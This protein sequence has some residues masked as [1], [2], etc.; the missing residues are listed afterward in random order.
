LRDSLLSRLAA[1]FC[2]CAWLGLG[3]LPAGADI[4]RV[5][6]V[7][8]QYALTSAND[9]P[10]R[11]PQ[12]W[13][14]LASND[15]G[16]TWTTL[17]VR[18]NEVFQARQQR[19]L[20]PL[21]QHA[22]YETY[23]LQIDRVRDPAAGSVQLAELELMGSTEDDLGP[24]P[25]FLDAISAQGDNPPAETVANLFDGRVETKWLDWSPH[26]PG[27]ISWVQWQY[28]AADGATVTN[29]SQLLA[30]R[31]RAG[32]GIRVRI[33]AVMA[34]RSSQEN[35]IYLVD[36]TGCI[37]LAGIEGAEDCG[38]GQKIMISGVSEWDGKRAGIGQG[39]A[40]IVG[41]LADANP[42]HLLLDHPLPEGEDLKWVEVEGEI[43]YRHSTGDETAF[44]VQ[45]ELSSIR[46]HLVGRK[47][48]PP[49]PRPGSRVLVRG[50]CLGAFNERGQWV[51]A[52]LWA[53][54]GES[55]II[56]DSHLKN[57]ALATLPAQ[58]P[59]APAVPATLTT[60]E[61]IR[62]LTREQLK[63]HPQ[64][65]IHAVV[66]DQL[67]GFV[68]D[69]T[70]GIEVWFPT[71]E[72]RK[73][74][75]LGDYIDINGWAG[76][77]DGGSPEIYA[78]H[79]TDAGRGKL[80]RPQKLSASQLM[81]GRIDGQ[82][83]EV[84]GVVHSTDGS[85]VLIISYGQELMATLTVAPASLVNRLVDADVRVRGVGVTATDDQGRVQ[86]THLLIPSLDY[87]DVVT[88]PIEPAKLPIRKIGS[89]LG[90]SGPL[91]S[92]HRVR[93]EGV[94]TLHEG[95]TVF[96]QDDTGSA[97]AILKENVVLGARFGHSRW[98]Y[99]QTPQSEAPTKPGE[100]YLP[101]D[102][103]MAV[104]FAETHRYSPVLTEATLTKLGVRQT[105]KP[106]A[107]T[108]G[109]I[110]EGGLDSS[111]VKLEG[112]LRNRNS[113]GL[114]TALTLEWQD[115]TLQVLVPGK[116]SDSLKLALGSRLQ[117]TGVCQVDPVPYA[118]LGLGIGAVRILTRSPEDVLVLARPP[119]WTARRALMLTGGMAL[120]I[121]AAL[122]WIKALRRQ[123]GER[124]RQ[125]TAEIQRREQTERHRALEQER[126]RIAK[127]LHDDL[128]ANLTQIVFLSDRVAVARHEGQEVTHWFDLIPATARRTIQSLDE[129]VWAINPRH[130]SL[131]SLANYL[132]QFAQQH[133]ALAGVRCLLDVPTV[134][135]SVPLTAEVRHNLL[136]TVREALQN[137]VT[138][139]AATEVQLALKLNE[140]G[141]S[142]T[143]ADNGRGFEPQAVPAAGDGLQ[144][145]RRRLQTIGGRLEIDSQPG[146]G[147]TVSLFVP[148]NVLPGQVNGG[149]GKPGQKL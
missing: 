46:V 34:G 7:I 101:G 128:G 112:V 22:A 149:N 140:D 75:E 50:I 146:R 77:D 99:W 119:W 84:D 132:S 48:S 15:G 122:I 78:D 81:S 17:D 47:D 14:L 118:K 16:R 74:R 20:Y 21:D 62:R 96:L 148:Q 68:Q 88:P 90:L 125:L 39:R 45:D 109:D 58:T 42:E 145:M 71:K 76:L 41:P 79:I 93:V 65:S 135:P 59:Q 130:D 116:G 5:K 100:A 53:A 106:A 138:H 104:G 83:I 126:T 40:Q 2:L 103:V 54:G 136:L 95:P 27:P 107:L 87:V 131:E 91:D 10:Q 72:K 32:D 114:N 35:K 142:V 86:G 55:L 49:L 6:K 36:A 147:T 9:F 67:E 31:M 64:V 108:A 24:T 85:H 80:P 141:I 69:A 3:I 139:A 12:D 11:D 127:D 124:T 66:T 113:M 13:R 60:I 111:L 18:K 44:E 115:R 123:V 110:E 38:T 28:A 97:M 105:L 8:Q 144:N 1:I 52:N 61:Q 143:V 73:I 94:V 121:L 134:L 129:I 43:Q 25:I 30:L 133:L 4:V 137:A 120:V 70:A 19:N 57:Q 23:R 56:L 63:A 82:W 29:I 26:E 89:L 33:E 37:E 51:A 102:R 92:F 98:S 117:V